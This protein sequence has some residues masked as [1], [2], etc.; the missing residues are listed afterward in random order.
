MLKK[1]LARALAAAIV[2]AKPTLVAEI[3]LY[4]IEAAAELSTDLCGSIQ[5]A[6]FGTLANIEKPKIVSGIQQTFQNFCA[7]SE[8]R[9]PLL[10]DA[11]VKAL[12]S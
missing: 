4:T 1:A 10:I 2:K 3:G 6:D 7:R 11:L 9:A 8:T 12:Q 5:D